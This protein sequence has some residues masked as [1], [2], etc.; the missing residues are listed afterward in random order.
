MRTHHH[1]VRAL[2]VAVT[3]VATRPALAVSP[4]DVATA[5]ELYKQGADALDAN[6]PAVAIEKLSAAWALLRT[7]VIGYALARA[8]DKLGHLIEAREATLAVARLPV[9]PDETAL[10]TAARADADKL[11]S[12][13]APRIPHLTIDLQGAA[14]DDA[15]VKLDGVVV[16]AAALKVSRQANPGAHAITAETADGRHAQASVSL[17]EGETREVKLT[18]PA[19]IKGVEP[20]PTKPPPITP[21]V[22]ATDAP[23][24]A[25]EPP[26]RGGLSP[27]VWIG[28][29][30]GAA[31]LAVGAI[32]G[33]IA[34]GTTGSLSSRCNTITDGTRVCPTSAAGDVSL[35]QTSATVSTIGFIALGVGAA[36][37]VTGLLLG[38]SS[39]PPRA[40]RVRPMLGP[41]SG[42][43]GAF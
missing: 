33:G 36:T 34:F 2:A 20:P 6:K 38:R 11:S 37:A 14:P 31:G 18:L 40:A 9:A 42:L 26:P 12:A 29:G 23:A 19:P 32:F 43:E 3:L 15:T 24:P 1:W 39:S 7:P 13:L 4:A 22:V 41:V 28:V 16:P 25:T 17:A 5:R 30:V 21:P 27:V 35:A 10:S 8:H